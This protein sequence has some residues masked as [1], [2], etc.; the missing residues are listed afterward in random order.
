MILFHGSCKKFNKIDLNECK[1][2]SDFGQ[3]FYLT[4]DKSTAKNWMIQLYSKGISKSMNVGRYLYSFDIDISEL[5]KEFTYKLFTVSAE[6]FYYIICNRNGLPC[7]NYDI[8]EGP[9]ADN[10]LKYILD[11]YQSMHNNG[12]VTDRKLFDLAKEA[13]KLTPFNQICIKNQK[14]IDKLNR[15]LQRSDL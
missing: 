9:I 3:G 15:C 1:Q 7:L 10:R 6:Y 8:I 13:T 12:L 4:H 5:K 14:I 2:G 11:R